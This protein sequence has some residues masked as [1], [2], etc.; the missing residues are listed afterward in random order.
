MLPLPLNANLR[1]KKAMLKTEHNLTSFTHEIQ[2][3]QAE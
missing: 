3:E 2:N 1:V